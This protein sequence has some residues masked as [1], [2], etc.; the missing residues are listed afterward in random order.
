VIGVFLLVNLIFIIF[1]YV[2]NPGLVTE[3]YYDKGQAYEQNILKIRA[4][5][6]ALRWETKLATPEAIVVNR[7]DTY[8]FSAVDHRGIPVM[9]AEV[10][11][12]AYRPSDADADIHLPLRQVAPGQ[13]QAE[14][15]LP[16]PGIWDINITVIDG[17]KRYETGRRVMAQRTP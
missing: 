12:V 14:L 6:A 9:D 11:M 17:D 15:G 2:T 8:R 13:Y 7:P 5:Q 1:A 4:A 3:D 10:T 16:L